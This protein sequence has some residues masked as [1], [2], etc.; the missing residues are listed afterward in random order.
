MNPVRMRVFPSLTE[1]SSEAARAI[2]AELRAAAEEFGRATLALAGGETPRALYE[3][4]PPRPESVP[5]ERVHVYWGDERYVPHDDPQS[6]YRM[7]QETLLDRVPVPAAH[8]HPM[9]TEAPDPDDAARAYERLLAEEF[10]ELPRFD[11]LILGLGADGHTASLFPD[12]AALDERE[13]WV[14]PS[15]ASYEPCQR[16]TLTLPVL[17]NARALHFL[18]AGAEKRQALSCAL[19]EPSRSCP[20]SLVRPTDG[21][22]TWWVDEAAAGRWNER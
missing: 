14:I 3:L 5:W 11:V 22:L 8:V 16:L 19:G 21:A 2:A 7:A 9:P 17:T 15:L 10:G 1:L 6:N 20:A 13:R 12:S 4:L 18:V